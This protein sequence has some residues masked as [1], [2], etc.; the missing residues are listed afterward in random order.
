MR[1][2]KTLFALSVLLLAAACSHAHPA[3]VAMAPNP[4]PPPGFR[5]VCSSIGLPLNAV[6]TKCTPAE[7][8]TVVAVR[9]KG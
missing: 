2:C 8:E 6:M 4:P 7:A 9:A 3:G 1:C 5:A